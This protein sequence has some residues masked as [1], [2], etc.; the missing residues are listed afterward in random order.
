M[1]PTERG[2]NSDGFLEMMNG[3][4]FVPLGVIYPAENTM[5]LADPVLIAFLRDETD[6]AGGWLVLRRRAAS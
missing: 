3:L 1:V 5:R 6:C 2:R 4:L